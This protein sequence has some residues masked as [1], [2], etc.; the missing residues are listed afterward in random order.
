MFSKWIIFIIKFFHLCGFHPEFSTSS[1]NWSWSIFLF[2]I[3]LSF[4]F[5]WSSIDLMVFI[6]LKVTKLQSLNAILP[7]YCGV[8]AQF[9]VISESFTQI[10]NQRN[11]WSVYCKIH[12]H[13]NI[14]SN[15]LFGYFLIFFEA[16]AM[17]FIA[18]A[19]AVKSVYNFQ[20]YSMSFLLFL[21]LRF[22]IFFYLF[23]SKLIE[24]ELKNIKKE[25]KKSSIFWQGNYRNY[26]IG[27]FQKNH[28]KFVRNYYKLVWELND[29]INSIFGWSNLSVVLFTFMLF[30]AQINWLYYYSSNRPRNFQIGLFFILC[31]K[32]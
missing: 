25:A 27:M 31:I 22:R 14:R 21:I 23:Y 32:T 5:M 8:I 12:H 7:Y 24:F 3:L 30:F 15:N 26:K 18:L 13:I 6:N 17:Y 1:K 9:I 29:N 28:K 4:C 2:H 19:L 16:F 10:K 20:H 11:F